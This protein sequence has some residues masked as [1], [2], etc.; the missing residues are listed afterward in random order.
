M[1]NIREEKKTRVG[2]GYKTK[3]PKYMENQF[4]SYVAKNRDNVLFFVEKHH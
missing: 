2:Q 1:H 4:E 3:L